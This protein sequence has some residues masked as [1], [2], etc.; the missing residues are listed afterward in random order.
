[1]FLCFDGYVAQQPSEA[2][3]KQN[4]EIAGIQFS[5]PPN[6]ELGQTSSPRVA[7]MRNSEISLFVA[8]PDQQIDDKYLID[9]SNFVARILTEQDAFDWKIRPAPDPRMSKYQ[10]SR[11]NTKGL[12]AKTYVQTDYV[13][14]KTHG[15]EILVGLVGTYG[16]G[17]ESAYQFEYEGAGYSFFG[18][19]AL[20]QL[21]SSI[22]GEKM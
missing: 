13:V 22:T 18:W 7:F 11:G 14:L 21:M 12:N 1:M 15:Q 10:I 3:P 20:F 4:S 8:V 19:R 2:G 16:E 9:I 6:F 17:L 5:T